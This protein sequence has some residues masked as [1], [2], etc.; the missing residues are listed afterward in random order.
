MSLSY[1]GQQ[2]TI[3]TGVGLFLIGIA[4]NGMN[5]LVL[6]TV[7]AYRTTPCTFYFLIGSIVNII[8]ILINLTTRIL[9]VGY[10]ID[11]TNT[12]N[13]FCKIREFFLITPAI[14]S[15]TCSCLAII[16]QF[17]VTSRIAYLRHCSQIKW[18]HRLVF[19][20]I[21]IWCL[22][23]IPI[24]LFFNITPRTNTCTDTNAVFSI[25]ALVYELGIICALPVL[26][27][28]VF[29]WLTYRNVHQIT[30][31]AEQNTDRQM[32]RMNLTQVGLLVISLLPYGIYSTYLLITE[33][34]TKDIN[35]QIIE[36]FV[37]NIL[38]METYFYY[39]V[40]L[41]ILC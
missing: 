13:I 34:V 16:D 35:R 21:V 40:C 7:R 33:S 32:V 31:L 39:V 14:L 25:Y 8:Y 10:G 23:G 18:A 1:I 37:F 5:I 36:Y 2:F 12:S 26:I 11:Y 9:N 22:H 27:M 19:I 30:I 17:F 24:I 6:S 3:Y 41:L 28:V 29:G 20:A 4:G 15:V 38:S